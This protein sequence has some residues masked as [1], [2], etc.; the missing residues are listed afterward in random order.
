MLAAAAARLAAIEALCPTSAIAV[1]S[2]FPT[3]ARDKVF[4]SRSIAIEEL[5]KHAKYTPTIGVYT[6]EAS[7]QLR[8]DATDASDRDGRTVL[9]FV[10]ELAIVVT[11][12]GSPYADAMAGDDPQARLVLEALCSQIDY[13]LDHGHSAAGA[14]WR[15]MVRRV[16]TSENRTFAVPQIGLRYQRITMTKV[17]EIRSDDFDV[18]A[19]QL[20]QPMHR[21]YSALPANS[22]ARAKLT[23]LAAHFNPDTLPALA[24]IRVDAGPGTTGI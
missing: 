1:Q 5:A 9:E 2:G 24:G 19:G 8:G 10:V 4:D 14:I 17:C 23:Q 20:P 15:Q 6:A 12:E 22:Y 21:L 13:V 7:H 3:L 16:V 11:D 18:P